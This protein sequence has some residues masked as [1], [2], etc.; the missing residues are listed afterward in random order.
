[1]IDDTTAPAPASSSDRPVDAIA[2]AYVTAVAAHN[3]EIAT[4]LGVRGYD[5]R[6][7]D[8]S[9]DGLAGEIALA[10]DTIVSLRAATPTDD[11]EQAARDAMLE[12]LG[13]QVE[14]HDA[15]VTPSRVSV[16]AGTAQ[17]I[18]ETFDLMPTEGGSDE[19]TEECWRNIARRLA[20]AATPLAQS[21]QTLWAESR[22]GHV[23]AVRQLT[24]TVE[25]IK[26]WT[27]QAGSA[28]GVDFFTGLV[29]RAPASL[30]DS[31][32]TELAEAADDA[33]AAFAAYGNWLTDELAPLAPTT[34]AVGTDRYALESRFFLGATV[35][36]AETYAWG[37]AELER[38]Q[39]EQRAMAT[40]LYGHTDIRQAC[41]SLDDDPARQVHG[42]EAFRDWMQELA[43]RAVGDLAGTQFDI[44][45]PIRTIECCL[46]PT[47]DG[48]IYYTGPTEDFSRPGRMWWSVPDGSRPSPPG[49]RPRRSTTRACPVTT[50][51][52]RRTTTAPTCS[53]AGSDSCAGCPVTVRAGP[54]TPS[55]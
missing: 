19:E 42:G 8:Y 48:G 33:R 15:H 45:D 4:T 36:L 53:T 52:S 14:L 17:G 13:L 7:S 37:W 23:S 21:R 25:Q 51:R 12:R 35:D 27:G 31:L 24:G 5:D 1:M 20:G 28:D 30:P 46:A 16:I 49:R 18:R 32:R 26:G 38:L 34:D 43:D 6:W 10:Q 29:D 2:D 54:C 44:P 41:R 22:E 9:P 55:G 39:D 3:P 40:E 50:S 11:R 47:H